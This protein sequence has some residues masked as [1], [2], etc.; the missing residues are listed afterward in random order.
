MRVLA[1]LLASVF[2]LMFGYNAV[3]SAYPLHSYN[4]ATKVLSVLYFVLTLSSVL[5]GFLTSVKPA[6]TLMIFGPVGYFIF[7]CSLLLDNFLLALIA[8]VIVGFTSAIYWICC[9]TIVYRVVEESKWG[10]AFGL[11]SVVAVLAGGLGPF[12]LLKIPYEDLLKIS[13]GLCLLSIIPLLPL[14]GIGGSQRDERPTLSSIRNC[15]NGK[16]ILYSV[17]AFCFSVNLP[18]VIAYIP[19]VGKDIVGEYRLISYAI[20]STFSLLGGS[21]YDKFGAIVIPISAL[22]ALI[23]FL[24]L[25][26]NIIAWGFILTASF[27]ILFPGFQA[28]LGKIVSEDKIPLALGFVGLISGVGVS[29]NIAVVGMLLSLS[30]LYLASLMMLGTVLSVCLLKASE[31]IK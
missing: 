1:L 27:S 24:N 25:P 7:A 31:K 5:A 21:L 18:I 9:R 8:S 10:F 26:H 16:L 30:W 4:D 29:L 17:V 12:A 15:L 14:Y 23:A 22:L 6:G 28:F 19:A 13:A 3:E 20:P 2:L 11:I